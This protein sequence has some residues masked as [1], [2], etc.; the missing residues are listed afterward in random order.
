MS[1][2]GTIHRRI[3]NPRNCSRH[4]ALVPLLSLACSD[5]PLAA[6]PVDEPP[7]DVRSEKIA[8]GGGLSLAV[9]EAG[10]PGG[11]PIVFIHGFTGNHLTW[12]RQFS[13]PL[14]AEFRLVAYDL[15]GHG[16][17]DK[18]LDPGRYTDAALWAEDLAAVIRSK[19]LDRP[20][21]VGWSYG[22]YVIS[23]YLRTFGDSAIGGVVFLGSST[24]NGTA[25]AA[26]FLTDEVL[27]RFGDVLSADVRKSLDATRALTRM[28]GNP[29]GGT[30]WEMAFGSAMMVP[31]EVR[32][33]MFSRVLDNDDVLTGIRVP[34]LVIHGTGDRI[35]RVSA[36]R[37]TASTVPGARLLL[38]DGV[39]HAVQLESAERLGRD[40]AEFVR[41]SRRNRTPR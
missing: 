38:Y 15:R 5:A 14:A 10:T 4:L 6:A 27:A 39:G 32:A 34:A 36:G 28:F 26:G 33:G 21:L 20:V 23:D 41:A 3:R 16:A 22:G 37:H 2:H 17:S 11:P 7:P 19:N 24:K 12:E 40:L 25:E 9:Y 31:P 29:L 8:G 13:G 30:A 35:V 1:A 18:P